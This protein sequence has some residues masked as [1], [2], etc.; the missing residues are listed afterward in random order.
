MS[1][2]ACPGPIGR[3]LRIRWSVRVPYYLRQRRA[4]VAGFAG[5]G[6]C[7]SSVFIVLGEAPLSRELAESTRQRIQAMAP[8]LGYPSIRRLAR[9]AAAVRRASA[10]SPC[11]MP[12]PFC[13]PT[14]RGIEEGLQPAEYC[15]L[16]VNAH[17]TVTWHDS[18]AAH[19]GHRRDSGRTGG[20]ETAGFHT[21][22]YR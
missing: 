18:A 11:D 12:N 3:C 21:G 7:V 10:P 8:R 13:I 4:G 15:S 14:V 6:E 9:W 22:F 16:V 17:T 1:S 20:G 5:K 2:S 19:R